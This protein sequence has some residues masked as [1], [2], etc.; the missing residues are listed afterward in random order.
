VSQL[1]DPVVLRRLGLNP[2]DE[3]YTLHD[4]KAWCLSKMGLKRYTLDACG[5]PESHLA[6]RW[7]GLQL[8]GSWR[9]G[10]LEPWSGDVWANIPFSDC[11]RW[12]VK[13]WS[14]WHRG[15]CR[16]IS[17]LLPNDKTEQPFWQ[18]W[19]APRRDRRGSPLRS[20]ELPGRTRFSAPGLGGRPVASSDGKPSSAFFGC[21]LLGWSRR[22]L[23]GFA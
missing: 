14:E 7:Y 15:R 11:E 12:L 23:R 20:F 17:L 21:Y 2:K 18:E 3:R 4:T 9:D 5:C 13:A 8:D 1:L 16:S 6:P 10:L 22:F 19:V